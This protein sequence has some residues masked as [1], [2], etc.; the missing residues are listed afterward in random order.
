MSTETASVLVLAEN[1]ANSDGLLSALKDR[2]AEGP[3]EFVLLVPG[4]PDVP[5]VPDSAVADLEMPDVETPQQLEDQVKEAVDRLRDEGLTVEGR[6]GD[7]DAVAAVE[8]AVNFGDFQEIIVAT[9]P[10][11][12]SRLLKVDTAR[13]IE[14]MTD[15]PVKHVGAD[16]S[17]E[18]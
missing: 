12:V 1:T 3:V 4:E 9:P 14:G 13:R 11:H 17:D 8:D 10:R 7:A 6:V 16:K 5:A 2:A 15:L 18:F